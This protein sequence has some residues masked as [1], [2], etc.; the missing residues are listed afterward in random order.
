MP[1]SKGQDDYKLRVGGWSDYYYSLIKFDI[2]NLPPN[3]L[4]AKILL[5]SF[6][7]GHSYR[8]SMYLDRVTSNWDE[9]VKWGTQST[10][11]SIGTIA[12]PILN[13]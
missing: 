8:T 9:R 1:S 7:D 2:S 5:Y 6:Y 3:V 11:Q 13:S 4:S 10:S 12:E